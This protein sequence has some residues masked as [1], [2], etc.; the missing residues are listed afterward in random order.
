M[1]LYDILF[2]WV[3]FRF[4]CEIYLTLDLNLDENS[5]KNK[6]ENFIVR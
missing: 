3:C 4:V 2:T 6:D 5:D 1:Y